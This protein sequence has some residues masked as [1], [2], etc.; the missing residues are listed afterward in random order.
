MGQFGIRFIPAVQQCSN[1]NKT[2]TV[3]N[4][5]R[6]NRYNNEFQI[7]STLMTQKTLEAFFRI[8]VKAYLRA[9][10]YGVFIKKAHVINRKQPIYRH[11]VLFVGCLVE[12]CLF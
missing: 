4:F 9:I 12:F 6:A 10:S 8:H 2:E 3:G 11:C 5:Q 7:A 1:W